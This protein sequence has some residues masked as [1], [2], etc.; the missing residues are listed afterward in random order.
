[1]KIDQPLLQPQPITIA[2]SDG[3]ERTFLI[4]KFPAIAGREIIAKY[5]LS[6]LPKLGDYKVNEETMFKLMAYVAVKTDDGFIRLLTPELI[7]NHV[8][9]WEVLVKIEEKM[10]EYNTSFFTGGFVQG[11]TSMLVE[12]AA[13][14]LSLILTNS[15]RALSQVDLQVGSNSE[16]K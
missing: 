14:I 10:L 16:T 2:D 4:S 6:A 1:M 12:K 13:P 11:F 8:V 9:D 15:L 7:N 5:P 3:V